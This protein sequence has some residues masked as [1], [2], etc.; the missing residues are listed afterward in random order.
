MLGGL[1]LVLVAAV[2]EGH[3]SHVDEE[4]VLPPLL[5]THLPGRLQKGLALD[6]AGG[7]ADLGDDHIRVG[8]LPHPVD[9]ILDLLGDVG[10]DLHRLAQIFAPALLVEHV[11]VDLAGGEVGV[12]I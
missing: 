11:P 8:G 4:G 1:G 12:A 3:Q 10:D 2:E 7:A 5:Q 9:K 6:V